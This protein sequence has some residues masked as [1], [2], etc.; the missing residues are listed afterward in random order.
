MADRMAGLLPDDEERCLASCPVDMAKASQVNPG[1][2]L[3]AEV[4]SKGEAK[5]QDTLD[6]QLLQET[7]SSIFSGRLEAFS[8]DEKSTYSDGIC[9]CHYERY[10]VQRSMQEKPSLGL[11]TRILKRRESCKSLF[12]SSFPFLSLFFFLPPRPFAANV[13]LGLS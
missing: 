7:R 8:H 9:Q 3:V 10:R 4:L 5:R 12:V 2:G 6:G 13:T 11:E 1:I